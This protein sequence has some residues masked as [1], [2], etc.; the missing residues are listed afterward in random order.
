[1]EGEERM[2][3][4]VIHEK[5]QSS[6]GAYVPD[7]TGVISVGDSREEV[8]HLIHEAIELHLEGVRAE[9]LPI[10]FPVKRRW[11][12]RSQPG[13]LKSKILNS[14][15]VA[16]NVFA[17][18]RGEFLLILRPPAGQSLICLCAP[19]TSVS[20][21]P[22]RRAARLAAVHSVPENLIDHHRRGV[23]LL[24]CGPAVSEYQI[25]MSEIPSCGPGLAR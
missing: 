14:A 17:E 25:L 2:R 5:G 8:E 6:W 1:M 23:R 11:R 12:H 18:K 7:F 15:Y 19:D 13:R 10:P 20:A 24:D 22:R 21:T 3:F 4:T 16:N 9:G